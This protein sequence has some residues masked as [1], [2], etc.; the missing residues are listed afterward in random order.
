MVVLLL[1]I[2]ACCLLFGGDKTKKGIGNIISWG[3]IILGAL[4]LLSSCT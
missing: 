4:A 3:F 1:I 2:I